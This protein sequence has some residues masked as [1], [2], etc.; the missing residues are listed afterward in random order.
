MVDSEFDR[1]TTMAEEVS[2]KDLL[3]LQETLLRHFDQRAE[4]TETKLLKAF[5]GWARSMKIRVCGVA[6]LTA[7]VDE[8]I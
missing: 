3:H 6:N 5:Y 1:A 8:R 4:Q 7:W 2:R